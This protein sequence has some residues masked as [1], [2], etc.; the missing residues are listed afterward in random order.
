MNAEEMLKKIATKGDIAAAGLGFVAGWPVDYVLLHMGVPPGTVSGYC[1]VGAFSLKKGVESWL[2]ARR[3][4]RAENNQ[5]DA[6]QRELLERAD[7]MQNYIDHELKDVEPAKEWS[8]RLQR[9]RSYWKSRIIKDVDFE[10]T[11]DDIVREI[12]TQSNPHILTLGRTI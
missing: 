6:K 5:I 3:K 7:A 11:M 2:D 4:K 8:E 1:A 12:D 9:R 10:Q